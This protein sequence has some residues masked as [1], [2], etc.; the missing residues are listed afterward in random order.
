MKYSAG[1]IKPIANP[2]L[3]TSK[4]RELAKYVEAQARHES[5]NYT[6]TLTKRYNNI[7][8]MRKP[9]VRPQI[10]VGDSGTISTIDNDSTKWQVYSNYTQAIEDLMLWMDYTRF[11]KTVGSVDDYS[12][13]MRARGFYTA[14][15]SQYTEG[16][17]KQL[18]S[19]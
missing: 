1:N 9:Y 10:S 2:V 4:Y 6:N 14:P 11:P 12:R 19:I 16:M 15:L 13:E 17:R 18:L 5:G 3:L 7:F 8:S